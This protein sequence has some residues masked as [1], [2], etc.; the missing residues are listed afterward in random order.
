MAV[1]RMETKRQEPLGVLQ[2]GERSITGECELDDA[3]QEEE[4]HKIGRTP[5]VCFLRSVLPVLWFA[6]GRSTY[7]CG[8]F[9]NGVATLPRSCN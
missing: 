3:G 9:A 7:A 4:E 2:S 1:P 6:G 8:C 5:Q